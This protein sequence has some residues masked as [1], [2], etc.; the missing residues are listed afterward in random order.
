V[1]FGDEQVDGIC[2]LGRSPNHPGVTAGH[3]RLGFKSVGGITDR[4]QIV[5][6]DMASQFEGDRLRSDVIALLCTLPA[7]QRLPAYAFPFSVTEQELGADVDVVGRLR[8]DGFR[9]VIRLPLRHKADRRVARTPRDEDAA[10]RWLLYRGEEKSDPEVIR[11][12][13]F[14]RFPAVRRRP[15]SSGC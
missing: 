9:T 15:C 1:G 10:E 11:S 3:K 13:R 8:T 2:S 6:E 14:G 5:P 7:D 4:P 12:S